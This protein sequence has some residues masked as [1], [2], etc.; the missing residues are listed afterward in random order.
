MAPF[1]NGEVYIDLIGADGQEREGIE[2]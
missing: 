1:A 2:A